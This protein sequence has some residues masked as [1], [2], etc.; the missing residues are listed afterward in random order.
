MKNEEIRQA[1]IRLVERDIDRFGDLITHLLKWFAAGTLTLNG[2]PLLAM[3]SSERLISKISG[4]GIFFAAGVGASL[5][6]NL[7]TASAFARVGNHLTEKHWKGETIQPDSYEEV[8]EDKTSLRR[9]RVG[10][11][12]LALSVVAFLFGMA[13]L[14]SELTATQAP[15]NVA[16]GLKK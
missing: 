15:T 4:S 3:L 16:Q 2:A 5:F 12:L 1:R 8:T 14:G 11:V 7:V 10:S 13:Q 6:G 9:L